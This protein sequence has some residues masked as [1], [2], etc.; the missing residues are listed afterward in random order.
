MW[1]SLWRDVQGPRAVTEPRH[2]RKYF[3]REP[4]D[5]KVFSNIEYRAHRYLFSSD[6]E[7]LTRHAENALGDDVLL[8]L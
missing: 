5:P 1:T 4:G 6:T 8:H 3:A 2:E 7:R